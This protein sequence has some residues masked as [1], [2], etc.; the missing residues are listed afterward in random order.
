MSVREKEMDEAVKEACIPLPKQ[1]GKKRPREFPGAIG[2]CI[3]LFEYQGWREQLH[4]FVT[5]FTRI[6]YEDNQDFADIRVPLHI[7]P[8]DV[9]LRESIQRRMYQL[10]YVQAL[11]IDISREGE[12]FRQSS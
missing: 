10:G 1:L 3:L 7:V 8:K 6:Y 11:E 9:A 2:E 4:S 5:E 12:A